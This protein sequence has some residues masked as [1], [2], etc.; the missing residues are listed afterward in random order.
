[1]KQKRILITGAN[2]YIGE[3]VKEYLLKEPEKYAVSVID[4]KGLNPDLAMFKPFDVVLNVA[5][6][7]HRKETD[8][9]RHLY[10]EINRD[11][12]VKIAKAAKEAG[13][14]QFILLSS[15]SVYGLIIGHIL[16]ETVPCPVNSY[17]RSKLE[18]DESIKQMVDKDFRFACL[19][20]PMVYGKNCKGNY[21][22][23]RK[24]ALTSP[25]F[26]AC[27]NKRSMIYIGNLCEFVKQAIDKQK[28]GLFFPQNAE[29]TN[30]GNMVKL[31]AE[32]HGKNIIVTSN[33]NWL[34]KLF[35]FKTFKKVFG[36]LTYEKEDMI[37]KFSFEDSI[38]LTEE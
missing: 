34:L 37:G 8:E 16:K 14:K 10:Y 20:L 23:L 25:V 30:T 19:R 28:S 18:A 29:Y 33:F 2:S 9:I 3:S 27:D 38:R 6:V 13:V 36:N 4:T 12:C 7:A 5:G 22:R 32:A 15:M 17:G 26:P 35:P 11:L 24:F 21:Q 31:I 1:M